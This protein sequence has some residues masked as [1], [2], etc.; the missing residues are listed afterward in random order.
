MSS[1]EDSRHPS[2]QQY[3]HKK[4]GKRYQRTHNIP[5]KQIQNLNVEMATLDRMAYNQQKVNKKVETVLTQ[6]SEMKNTIIWEKNHIQHQNEKN[7]RQAKMSEAI[8]TQQMLTERDFQKEHTNQM[9]NPQITLTVTSKT[10]RKQ[11]KVKKS[12][13]FNYQIDSNNLNSSLLTLQAEHS[14]KST[15]LKM[16]SDLKTKVNSTQMGVVGLPQPQRNQNVK[17]RI[18]DNFHEFHQKFKKLQD[19]RVAGGGLRNMLNPH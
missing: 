16:N 10:P 14:E 8:H 1:I 3:G 4:V 9:S 7:L 5:E 6:S 17:I 15:V 12:L 18:T 2:I 19:F 13:E 11:K